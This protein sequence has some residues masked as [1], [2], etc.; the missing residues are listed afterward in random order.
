VCTLVTCRRS[1]RSG[2]CPPKN[3]TGL[4][5][6]SQPCRRAISAL[7][8]RTHI[9]PL[10]EKKVR[11]GSFPD[12]PS[13]SA[14]FVNL[15]SQ[16]LRKPPFFRERYKLASNP[17]M[18]L[19]RASLHGLPG[20]GACFGKCDSHATDNSGIERPLTPCSARLTG[21]DFIRTRKVGFHGVRPREPLLFRQRGII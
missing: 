14:R 5:L 10:R 6:P 13:K 7:A 9:A 12:R 20:G 8:L 11:I 3:I 15:S 1:W 19:Q 4:A 21:S 2:S 16:K 18:W 17:A